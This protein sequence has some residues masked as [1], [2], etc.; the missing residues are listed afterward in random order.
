M[1]RRLI[2]RIMLLAMAAVIAGAYLVQAAPDPSTDAGV[3]LENLRLE[4][5]PDLGLRMV[6]QIGLVTSVVLAASSIATEY[7]WGTIRSVLSRVDRHSSFLTAKLTSAVLFAA[8]MV[9]VGSLVAFGASAAVTNWRDL[10]S[11]AGPDAASRF[12][13]GPVR[14]FVAT[15]PYLS[16]AFLVALWSRTTAAGFGVVI[17]AFYLDVLLGPLFEAGNALAWV[18][19][20]ALIWRNVSALLEA[21][22]LTPD[23]GL[24]EPSMAAAVLLGYTAIFIALAYWR[25]STRDVL[26][27]S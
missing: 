14:V 27:G 15:L 21:N 23:A 26:S 10:D 1:R 4:N 6:L 8:V 9:A 16:L 2:T 25:F 19:E 22:S 24:P 5:A 17:A 20:N 11:G 7:G 12:L 18:P 13:L 3:S